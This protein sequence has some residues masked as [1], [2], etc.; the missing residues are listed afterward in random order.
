MRR[1]VFSGLLAAMALFLVLGGAHAASCTAE[2]FAAAVDKSGAQLRAFNSEALPK[3]QAKLKHSRTEGLDRRRRSA[4]CAMTA[5]GNSTS[6]AEDLIVKIDQLGPRPRRASLC[7]KLANSKRPARAA[8]GDEA[9]PPTRWPSSTAS[10]PAAPSR[11]PPSR[12]LP[13]RCPTSRAD[14]TPPK[15]VVQSDDAEVG[16]A[17]QP[18][19]ATR[20]ESDVPTMEP[21]PTVAMLRR[22]PRGGRHNIDEIREISRGFFGTISTELGSVLEYAFSS[23]G[24]P[25]GSCSARWRGA[26]LAGLRYGSGKLYMRAGGSSDIY[27]HGPSIAPTS[28]LDR[29]PCSRSTACMRPKRSTGSSPGIDGSAYFIGGFGIT[30]LKASRDQAPIRTGLVFRIGANN[31][32][33][34]RHAAPDLEPF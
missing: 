14:T 7:A 29:A 25:D 13:R 21:G 17:D 19:P 18:H 34:P 12:R 15:P 30:F 20:V 22:W 4:P 6:K 32:L 28:R 8:G 3:L 11:P 26:F 23:A 10:L 1:S 27:W 5:T 33:H 16:D 9:S 2:Q 24:R 31:R